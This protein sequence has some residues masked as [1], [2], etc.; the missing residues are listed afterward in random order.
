MTKIE[1]F[2]SCEITKLVA[3]SIFTL[4]VSNVK[5]WFSNQ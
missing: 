1:A 2:T 4:T 3:Q 5:S